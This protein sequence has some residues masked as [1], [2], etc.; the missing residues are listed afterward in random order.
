VV[1][2]RA[3]KVIT[4]TYDLG[5]CWEHRVVVDAVDT[6]VAGVRYPRCLKATGP[7]PAEYDGHRPRAVDLS[8][9]NKRC[10]R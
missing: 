1:A 9:V 4:Y 8:T 6:A 3:G 2:G 7:H 10:P 5:A